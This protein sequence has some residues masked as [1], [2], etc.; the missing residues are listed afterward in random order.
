MVSSYCPVVWMYSGQGSQY[1]AMGQ[2]LYAYEP[3]FRETF[4]ELSNYVQRWT[5]ESIANVVYGHSGS[6]FDPFD[7]TLFTHPALFA[8]QY[9]MDR[10]LRSRGLQPDFVLGYSLG[11][12]VAL[13][14]SGVLSWKNA[15]YALIHHAQILERSSSSGRMMAILYSSDLF[16][17]LAKRFP[18]VELAAVNTPRHFVVTGPNRSI[19]QMQQW[20]E[21]KMIDS[22]VLPVTQAFHS[23]SL[24]FADISLRQVMS[25]FPLGRLHT[26]LVSS[27]RADIFYELNDGISWRITRGA[28]QFQRALAKLEASGPKFYVDL[29]P[30]GTLASFVRQNLSP[31]VA[32]EAAVIMTPFA[33]DLRNFRAVEQKLRSVLSSRS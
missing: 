6:R 20:L 19:S 3:V 24:E 14:V 28:I 26:P 30:S 4:Q 31:E 18:E 29:G 9:A 16:T 1:F 10:T 12:F 25:S 17:E 7:K 15:L 2:E 22:V 13:S 33:Q 32:S 27:E 21:S 11:E 23:K 8:V 5:G